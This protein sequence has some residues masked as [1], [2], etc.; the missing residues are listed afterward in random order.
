MRRLIFCLVLL[1]VGACA[2]QVPQRNRA[3]NGPSP[4]VPEV[5]FIG[6]QKC[7]GARPDRD[8]ATGCVTTSQ[9]EQGTL[10]VYAIVG[11]DDLPREWRIRLE[12]DQSLIDQVL[13]AGGRFSYPHAIAPMDVNSDGVEEWLIKNVDL[14]SHGTNWQRLQLLTVE[15]DKLVPI[16]LEDEPFHVNVGGPS[17]MGEGARCDGEHFVLLRTWALDRQ[18]TKW[19][20]SE[21]FYEVEGSAATFVERREGRYEVTDYNDP[22]IDPYYQVTCGSF[23]YP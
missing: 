2:D 10:S 11:E 9:G 7:P 18:N 22:K 15:G 17:R 5:D 19:A 13:K 16:R 4:S 12:T 1:L 20:Y 14:A 8:P 21:R 6:G 3:A 23:V